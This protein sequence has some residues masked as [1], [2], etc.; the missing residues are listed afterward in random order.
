MFFVF[1]YLAQRY[2]I[3]CYITNRDKTNNND[4]FLSFNIVVL[5]LFLDASCVII[6]LSSMSADNPSAQA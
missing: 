6:I 5:Y 4:M 1:S 3:I 2:I